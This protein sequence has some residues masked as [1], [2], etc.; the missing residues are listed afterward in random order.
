MATIFER[1]D[2]EKTAFINPED[3]IKPEPDFPKVCITTFSETMTEK[4]AGKMKGKVIAELCSANGAVPVYEIIYKGKQIALFLSRVGAP[5]CTAGLEEV[6]AMGAESIVMFGCCGVLD[7]EKVRDRIIIPSSAVRDEGTSYHYIP[8]SEEIYTEEGSMRK[9]E[10]CLKKTGLPYVTG[11]TWTTDAVYRETRRVVE[12]RK[13]QG[14][15]AVEMEC[16]AA[17]A[18]TQ[19]RDVRFLPFLYGADSLDS[20]EWEIRDLKEYGITGFHKYFHLALE[21]ALVL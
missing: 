15:L 18:V 6:I 12:E 2:Y 9:L 20:D 17:L 3:V 5:A 11:K 1:F 21:C 8:S 19:F 16:S 13:E 7:Q 10:S 14:C 4:F